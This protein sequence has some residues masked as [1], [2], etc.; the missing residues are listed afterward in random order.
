MLT[1]FNEVNLQH[2]IDL[3]SQYK[4][5]FENRHGIKLGFM[6]F[7]VKASVEALKHFPVVNASIDGPHD[8]A[9]QNKDECC[10]S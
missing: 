5:A 6:S 1:T 3:R 9:S 4:A 7:F 2:V 8:E 10:C